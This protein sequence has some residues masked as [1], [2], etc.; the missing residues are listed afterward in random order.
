MPSL[1][2]N[3]LTLLPDSSAPLSKE[4][5]FSSHPARAARTP[6][7]DR[8][9]TLKR[10]TTAGMAES[11]ALRGMKGEKASRLTSTGRASSLYSTMPIGYSP[12]NRTPGNP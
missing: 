4:T 5:A 9:A 12:Q 7:D 2:T 10:M 3:P 6:A 1:R 11:A 8:F